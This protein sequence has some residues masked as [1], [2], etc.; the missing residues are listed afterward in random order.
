[1]Q[2]IC[3][4]LFNLTAE[5]TD[6]TTERE[7][8]REGKREVEQPRVGPQGES[9]PWGRSRKTADR[10]LRRRSGLGKSAHQTRGSERVK[11]TAMLRMSFFMG[12]FR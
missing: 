5:D 9:R 1:M 12:L 7:G 4:F 6:Y 11:G 10:Q 3:D 2:K 8:K